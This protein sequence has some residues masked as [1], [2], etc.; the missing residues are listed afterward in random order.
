M[1]VDIERRV[2]SLEEWKVGHEGVSDQ[3]KAQITTLEAAHANM[4][5]W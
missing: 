1:T 2:T 5:R 3:L 4:E